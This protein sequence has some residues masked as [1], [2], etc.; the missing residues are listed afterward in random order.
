[1][2]DF[3]HAPVMPKEALDLLA[4]RSP[5]IY[6][7]GTLGGGGHS[8]LILEASSPD[9]VL[10][11]FDRDKSALTAASLK[12][13][14]Y[15]SRFN[16]V[17]SNF[18]AMTDSLKSSGVTGIDGF[19]LDLGVSSHQL[20]TIER[21]FSFQTDAPLDMRM[22]NGSGA[23]AADLV[24]ELPESELTR[25]IRD[26]GEERWAQRIAR[27]IVTARS[28]NP[29]KT[30]MHLVDIIKGAIPNGAW[31]ERLHPATRTFQALRIATNDEL[32]SLE[33]GLAAGIALL[34][35]GG[36]GVIISFHSLEDRIVKHTFR[37]LAKGCICPRQLPLC[38]CGNVPQVK[39]LTSRALRPDD[40][41]TAS[42]P[43]ARSARLRAVEKR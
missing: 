42:N 14:E 31:E 21:G 39:I 32:G 17:H 20:D 15:G 27:F 35:P 11:G 22:D 6:V 4:P 25:I 34:K 9:G 10:Y 43:R 1:M 23:T 37:E 36:R 40:S 5:G 7:D 26:Y 12:L 28:E 18:A 19:L 33:R 3:R 13:A 8:R 2:L 30:T 41:E 38:V 24:N 29:L 16:P